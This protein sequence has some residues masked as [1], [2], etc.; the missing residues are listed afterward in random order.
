[1]WYGDAQKGIGP[2]GV[3]ALCF[4]QGKICCIRMYVRPSP[5]T[6]DHGSFGP[7]SALSGSKSSKSR[8]FLTKFGLSSSSS[9]FSHSSTS[10]Q[11]T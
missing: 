8:L 10:S 9:S 1:M 7:P 5:S 6:T 11:L 2:E 4:P 3:D